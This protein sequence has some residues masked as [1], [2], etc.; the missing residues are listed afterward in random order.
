MAFAYSGL[1]YNG[2]YYWA[3]Q[4]T[5]L[6]INHLLKQARFLK[7]DVNKLC[8]GSFYAALYDK[9]RGISFMAI[10]R[11]L[12]IVDHIIVYHDNIW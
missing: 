8:P 10:S 3:G 4:E 1:F 2:I 11:I 6:E 9:Q 5:N 7:S 12:M